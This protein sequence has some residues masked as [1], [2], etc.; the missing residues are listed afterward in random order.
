MARIR[1]VKPELRTS[2]VVASWPREVRYFFVLLWGYLDDKGRGLDVPK[3]IAGD[4]FPHDEDVT[5]AKVNRWLDLMAK[6]KLDPNKP[7]PICR[8]EVGGR[9]YVHCVNWGEH[10]RA[11]RPTPS[12]LPQ[13][14]VHEPLSESLPEPPSGDS[15]E[16]LSTGLSDSLPGAAEQ[17]SRGAEEQQQPGSEPLS[18][19]HRAA[20]AIIV[21]ATD[22]T[23]AEAGALAARI[24]HERKPRN[25]AGFVRSL[26][27]G[28]DLAGLLAEVRRDAAG[29]DVA[30]AIAGAR[31][32]P[33]CPHGE[34]GG[35]FPHPTTGKPLCPLCRRRKRPS[36]PEGATP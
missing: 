23:P 19:R 22:A 24:D 30:A 16:K 20:A 21:D 6:T 36:D 33:P 35:A 2:E 7:P 18:E 27:N 25:L 28:P 10:Q 17:G 29:S 26:G 9:R 3:T 34:P 13:C 31:K 12:R 14:P 1:S 32:G 11:N 4:C 15:D 8:Y 5:P